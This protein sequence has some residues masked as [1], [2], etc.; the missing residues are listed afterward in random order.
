MRKFLAGMMTFLMIVSSVSVEGFAAEPAN[1]DA[2]TDVVIEETVENEEI[3]EDEVIPNEESGD[4]SITEEENVSENEVAEDEADSEITDD[5][6]EDDDE[7][8]SEGEEEFV[9]PEDAVTEEE[10]VPEEIE[11][12]S[13]NTEEIIPEGDEE[14]LGDPEENMYTVDLVVNGVAVDSEIPSIE[15]AI[16]LIGKDGQPGDTY[17]CEFYINPTTEDYLNID[18]NLPDC[19]ESATFIESD[20]NQNTT[21]INIV[22]APLCDITVNCA[23][24]TVGNGILTATAYEF[25]EINVID[26]RINLYADAEINTLKI[27]CENESRYTEVYFD[28]GDEISIGS[29]VMG[30]G[31]EYGNAYLQFNPEIIYDG[32]EIIEYKYNPVKV[33]SISWTTATHNL[34]FDIFG[35]AEED[36]EFGIAYMTIAGGWDATAAV[37]SFTNWEIHRAGTFMSG[38]K[39]SLMT[40]YFAPYNYS[41]SY[42]GNKSFFTTVT[43]AVSFI[44]K[45]ESAKTEHSTVYT[46]ALESYL[47]DDDWVYVSVRDLP[48]T[49]GGLSLYSKVENTGIYVSLYSDP[50]ERKIEY[51]IYFMKSKYAGVEGNKNISYSEVRLFDD[52]EFFEAGYYSK[53]D[54]LNIGRTEVSFSNMSNLNCKEMTISSD[55]IFRYWG[56][57]NNTIGETEFGK[58]AVDK[59]VSPNGELRI[60]ANTDSEGWSSLPENTE[61]GEAKSGLKK[62]IAIDSDYFDYVPSLKN[63]KIVLVPNTKE[64]SLFSV[65]YDKGT[66]KFASYDEAYNWMNSQTKAYSYTITPL[67]APDFMEINAIPAKAKKVTFDFSKAT[68]WQEYSPSWY[69][70]D[71]DTDTPLYFI[72]GEDLKGVYVE[73]FGKTSLSTLSLSS[74]PCGVT[75][76]GVTDI[77]SLIIKDAPYLY[78]Y[79]TLTVENAEFSA[80]DEEAMCSFACNLQ[81][82]EEDNQY[83][84][85]ISFNHAKVGSN[86]KICVTGCGFDELE[87][88]Y[89]EVK[90]TDK[91]DN[92]ISLGY[93][94]DGYNIPVSIQKDEKSVSFIA[95]ADDAF[96]YVID[97]E[98]YKTLD[99]VTAAVKNRDNITVELCYGAPLSQEFFD[100]LGNGVTLTTYDKDAYTYQNYNDA[101]D[102]DLNAKDITFDRMIINIKSI[103]GDDGTVTVKNY[104]TIAIAA[105]DI[106][107]VVLDN[108]CLYFDDY[109]EGTQFKIDT[110]EV[111]DNYSEIQYF[112]YGEFEPD[113]TINTVKG[114]Q[115]LNLCYCWV[116][117]MEWG[118]SE[119]REFP[120]NTPIL[121]TNS[122]ADKFVFGYA[123]ED[124]VPEIKEGKLYAKAGENYYSISYNAMGGSVPQDAPTR[125][126]TTNG[127]VI[128]EPFNDGKLGYFFDGWYTSPS[129]T[130]K[131]YIGWGIEPGTK[132]NL[133]LYAKWIPATYTIRFAKDSA[134]VKGT[135][136]DRTV[137]FGSEEKIPANTLKRPGYAFVGWSL[138]PDDTEV[139]YTD[140][141]VVMNLIEPTEESLY[142]TPSITLHPVWRK[143][144]LMTKHGAGSYT[145]RTVSG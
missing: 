120:E 76:N 39:V 125:Y 86:A 117:D 2:D 143:E 23:D 136:K 144:F 91:P 84:G 27:S 93:M 140:K 59:L 118:D 87:C 7:V 45:L 19:V 72:D 17:V 88:K 25:D 82:D 77:K 32:E 52:V 54:K 71:I 57:Y 137:S 62:V 67:E 81:T 128:P 15:D 3:E 79:N 78:T 89:F 114:S 124:M 64:D 109:V 73:F 145:S 44:D 37:Y 80:S 65:K 121:S 6:I 97:G 95:N 9:E 92:F 129:F 13:A 96:F 142:N 99:D 66:K 10:I 43:Q 106:E 26:G 133:T 83:Q 119:W 138:Y 113:I 29:L 122:A 8:I 94:V 135:M 112:G 18:V 47:G 48:L 63:G 40:E 36:I 4:E 16:E 50:E 134:D 130:A 70:N 21:F 68:Y 105:C 132:G 56:C 110:I 42:D 104:S 33:N 141:Q 98:Q 38:D 55:T 74:Y 28:L 46:I 75:F 111:N 12:E 14:L 69:F 107:K 126:G 30:E 85:I 35:V 24:V 41:V 127:A 108:S 34:Y 115:P 22:S 100:S 90:E 103:A 58:F 49:C 5:F 31:S 123:S 116:M 20:N 51:P 131:S 53:I 60:C 61:L 11:E 139:M 101:V 102:V 1:Y